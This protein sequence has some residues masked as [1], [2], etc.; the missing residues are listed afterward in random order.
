MS[1]DPPDP[2][3]AA[4]GVARA[5]CVA[6]M[7]HLLQLKEEGL[8]PLAVRVSLEPDNVMY[9]VGSNGTPLPPTYMNSLDCELVPV[10]HSGSIFHLDKFSR[11]LVSDGPL[12][13]L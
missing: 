11:C 9:E 13:S 3:R 12:H 10:L 8:S 6:L 2:A 5:V 7:P 4:E 1:G